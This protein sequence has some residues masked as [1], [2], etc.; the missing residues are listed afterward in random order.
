[1]PGRLPTLPNKPGQLNRA[2]LMYRYWQ[3][4]DFSDWSFSPETDEHNPWAFAE[5][6]GASRVTILALSNDPDLQVSGGILYSGPFFFDIDDKDLSRALQ[7]SVEL[8]EKLMGLGVA[9]EDLE[10]HLSGGKGVHIFL[11]SRVFIEG[12]TATE[13]LPLIYRR[14]ALEVYVPGLDLQVYSGGRGRMVRPPDALRP[15]GVYKVLVTFPELKALS[16]EGYKKLVSKP[17]GLR[18]EGALKRAGALT[19]MFAKAKAEIKKEEKTKANK[20]YQGLDSDGLAALGGE[21]PPCV[22]LLAD[23]GM[24]ESATLNQVGLNLACWSAR[25][26]IDP[27]ALDSIHNRIVDTNK[28]SNNGSAQ[29]RKRKLQAMHHYVMAEQRF[30]FSCPSMLVN[31]KH[32]PCGTCPLKEV[33]VSDGIPDSIWVHEKNGNW[34]SDAEFTQ[35]VST[36]TMERDSVIEDELTGLKE[37]S[38][39]LVHLAS[40]G[41]TIKIK[42]FDERSWTSK[43]SFKNQI[44]GIDGA[45]FFGN[46][47][48]VTRMRIQLVKQSLSSGVEMDTIYKSTCVGITYRRRRGPESVMDENH[49][50]RLTY[51]EPGFSIN[52]GGAFDT[53]MYVGSNDPA[54]KLSRY[55]FNLPIPAQ[56]NKAFQLLCDSNDTEVIAPMLGWYLLAHIKQHVFQV[57]HRG[58]LLCVSGVAGTGKNSLTA[59]MQRLCGLEGEAAM[60]TLEAPNATK[61]PFQQTCSNTT[62]IPRIIN[63]LNPKSISKSHYDFIIEIVKAAFDSRPISKGRLG[64]GDKHG[65]NVSSTSWFVTAP[66]VTL[67]EEPITEPAV[68]QRAI[69]VDMTP[70]GLREGSKAFNQLEPIADELVHIARKLVYGALRTSVKDIGI[71]LKNTDLPEIVQATNIPAR[72]KFGYRCILV[73]YDWALGV[74]GEPDS[75]FDTDSYQYLKRMRKAFVTHIS[76]NSTRI[77]RDSNVTEVDKVIRDMAVMAYTAATPDHKSN[78]SFTRGIHYVVVGDRLYIDT[79]IAYPQYQ[80]FKAGSIE[81]TR[82]KSAE[83]FLN[84]VRSMAYYQSDTATTEYL[85]TGG[86]PVLCLD[87]NLLQEAGIPTKMF[88]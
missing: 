20:A 15:D 45:G 67:S 78:W 65:A 6:K 33:R 37:T 48:D 9:E 12:K 43:Q 74:L 14:L 81:G 71:R 77:A 56:A 40:H 85:P 44:A 75:G 46:D 87:F 83:A 36:F 26:N 52:D 3:T 21:V 62:T 51:V 8:C 53:H 69:M 1:M 70:K 50:G 82:I 27:D 7:S 47:N 28:S 22:E 32:K 73:A 49:V 55:D 29:F 66:V 68:M 16:P 19:G 31:L 60:F 86:R 17:R 38:V 59:V 57:E 72:L 76:E 39:I 34:Y 4:S 61:V 25:V 54:P 79:L 42:D 63:E 88:I 11:D 41:K 64:G 80:K 84:V 24:R 10:I 30:K 35:L 5:A 18:H 13:H 58:I 23:G 2:R